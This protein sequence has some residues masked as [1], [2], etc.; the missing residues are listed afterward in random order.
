MTPVLLSLVLGCRP[1]VQA[2]TDIEAM[3]AFGFVHF[4]DPDHLEAMVDGAFTWLEDERA[5]A[6]EAG[7]PSTVD[8]EGY[9]VDQL[10]PADLEAA[11]VPGVDVDG[12]VGA[13]GAVSYVIEAPLV[14]AGITHP[15][16]GA[17]Y[18]G[19]EQWEILSS[20]G[21][22][23][24]FLRGESD[25]YAFVA[26]EVSRIPLLGTATRTTESALRW[27]VGDAS[28]AR[29]LAMRQ[30]DPDPTDFTTPL[31][32]VDQQ[33]GLTLLADAPD[34]GTLRLEAIWVDARVLGAELPEGFAVRQAVGRMAKS[35]ADM[36]AY[37]LDGGEP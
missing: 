36:D 3:M 25:R 6:R 32:A 18:E 27:V 13:L 9:A 12:I 11:G 35:A 24:D 31:L 1:A 19:T 20:E 21:S 26:S 4:D 29:F 8:D 37:F 16:K 7:T 34:G 22:R 2:P 10:T 14:A 17:I 28:G 5:R 23:E 30:L 33:Y 15:D